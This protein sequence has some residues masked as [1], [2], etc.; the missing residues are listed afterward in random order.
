M[1]SL[2]TK[3]EHVQV[4]NNAA[5]ELNRAIIAAQK[6]DVFSEIEINQITVECLG[7]VDVMS[8]TV[9]IVLEKK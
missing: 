5:M 1:S 7:K 3:L 2:Q 6:D 8:V 9:N 4:L